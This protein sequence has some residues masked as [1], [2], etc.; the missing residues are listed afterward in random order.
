M[1]LISYSYFFLPV[2][3]T[4]Y[5]TTA[6][7]AAA[8]PITLEEPRLEHLETIQMLRPVHRLLDETKVSATDEQVRR[9]YDR[10]LER[11]LQRRFEAIL[12]HEYQ[13][14]NLDSNN[15]TFNRLVEVATTAEAVAKNT[16]YSVCVRPKEVADPQEFINSTHKYAKSKMVKSIR[17]C[18]E[19]GTD[20]G[21]MQGLHVHMLI[22]TT[23]PYPKSVIKQRTSQTYKRFGLVNIDVQSLRD[24]TKI[25]NTE[26]Y[27]GKLPGEDSSKHA[28]DLQFRREFGLEHFYVHQNDE[29]A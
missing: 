28:D 3:M 11:F 10:A 12:E 1:G 5:A 17:Y 9:A 20:N 6:S 19:T 29:S 24:E 8:V 15:E 18:F 27:I 13:Q 26:Q 22:Y 2:D 21:E 7:E 23:D 25:K 14:G 4:P 16:V